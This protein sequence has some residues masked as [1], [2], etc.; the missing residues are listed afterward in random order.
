MVID[1]TLDIQRCDFHFAFIVMIVEELIV[2]TFITRIHGSV[3]CAYSHTIPVSIH[4]KRIE[5]LPYHADKDFAP[6]EVK[7]TATLKS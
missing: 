2:P 4:T 1:P 3:A 6:T 5:F 7:F